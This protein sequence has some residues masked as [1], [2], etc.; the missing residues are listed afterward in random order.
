[1]ILLYMEQVK[2]NIKKELSLSNKCNIDK[3]IET[4]IDIHK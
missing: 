4:M 3:I 2:E 1:V